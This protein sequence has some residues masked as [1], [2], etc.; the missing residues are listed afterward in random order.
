MRGD[1]ADL[2][3]KVFKKV[4]ESNVYGSVN[5]TIPAFKRNQK[6]KRKYCFFQV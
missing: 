3:P 6:N 2:N 4:F 1:L 5:P